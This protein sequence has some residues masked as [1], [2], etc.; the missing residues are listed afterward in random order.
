MGAVELGDVSKGLRVVGEEA[1]S[2]LGVLLFAL[3]LLEVASHG[4]CCLVVVEEDELTPRGVAV[5]LGD[6]PDDAPVSE[7]EA[8]SD[9]VIDFSGG[10]VP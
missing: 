5:A 10:V 6:A 4:G 3:V 2:F 1:R 7:A 8:F 9:G